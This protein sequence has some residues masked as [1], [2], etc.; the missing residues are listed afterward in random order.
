LASGIAIAILPSAQDINFRSA[1]QGGDPTRI[2][3]AAKSFPGHN[4]YYNYSSQIFLTNN[5]EDKALELSRIAVAK[6][7]RD[8]NAWKT[9]ID[10]P[11]IS[12]SEKADAIKK[13]K[14]L[15]PFNNTLG[16]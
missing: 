11:K 1:L 3:S 8:F 10:N 5:L 2:E 12:S 9:L 13:M 6:N 14:E 16:Q 7:P 4:Y 15:D